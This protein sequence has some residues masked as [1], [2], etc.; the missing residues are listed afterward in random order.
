MRDEIIFQAIQN[1]DP[2]FLDEMRRIPDPNPKLEHEVIKA[3]PILY[4]FFIKKKK[5]F[6]EKDFQTFQH[7]LQ[8][9]IVFVQTLDSLAF[10]Y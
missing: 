7:V 6:H 3:L 9:E 4:R 8:Q 2:A 1:P 10:N 5:A